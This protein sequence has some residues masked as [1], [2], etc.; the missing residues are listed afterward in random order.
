[1]GYSREQE[2]FSSASSPLDN[3]RV[4]LRGLG[5]PPTQRPR[6]LAI[7]VNKSIL[8]LGALLTHLS[9]SHASAQE[10]QHLKELHLIPSYCTAPCVDYEVSNELQN[11]WVFSADPSSFTS[12]NLYPTLETVL[13]VAPVDHLRLVGNVIYEPVLDVT[14][15]QS[16]AFNNL[17][18]YVDQLYAQFEAGRFN[19]Q[20][21]KIHPPFG[22][23]WDVT[24]GLHGT[25]IPG[26]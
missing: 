19:L 25:D 17:G 11:D 15:G 16:N 21:G 13:A 8:I 12:N 5:T 23:A 6:P 24:P 18:L 2:L 1:L 14:P 7:L 10:Q 26:H 20:A 22:R 9:V 3:C 4:R